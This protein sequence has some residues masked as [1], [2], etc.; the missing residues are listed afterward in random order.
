M[1]FLASVVNWKFLAR[2][3]KLIEPNTNYV[4]IALPYFYAFYMSS[5]KG[6]TRKP[7]WQSLPYTFYHISQ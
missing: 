3:V 6:F 5:N 1:D 2:E 4:L 7:N